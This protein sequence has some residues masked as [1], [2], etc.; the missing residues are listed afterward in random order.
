[1]NLDLLITYLNDH[2]AGATAATD[3]IERL[4]DD[5]HGEALGDFATILL[6][7]IE[8]DEQE[9][10]GLIQRYG[11][12]PGV[13]KK[14]VAWAATKMTMPKFDRTMAGSFGN[15]QALEFLSMGV[16]G[17]RAL[18]R[19]LQSLSDPE[20]LSVD[21]KKLIERADSQF[22]QIEQWRIRAGT[23][24]ISSRRED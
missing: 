1:M 24:A 6:R 12:A 20:L 4:I 14:A 8:Q 2:R 10:D 16:L 11:A 22:E 13:L 17:K 15:F 3:V 9:L 5:N 18:W 19:M 23:E 21:Y 7:E